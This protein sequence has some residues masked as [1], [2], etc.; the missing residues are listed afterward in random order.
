MNFRIVDRFVGDKSFEFGTG[1]AI[2]R[3]G[4]ARLARENDSERGKAGRASG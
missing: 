2:L 4:S 1:V 3:M